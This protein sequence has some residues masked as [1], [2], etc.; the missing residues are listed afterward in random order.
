MMGGVKIVATAGAETARPDA[1]ARAIVGAVQTELLRRGR[2]V[3]YEY[4][5]HV[6]S[7][8]FA[9]EGNVLVFSADGEGDAALMRACTADIEAVMRE[10]YPFI[11]RF[12]VRV[13][14]K[15]EDPMD[16]KIKRAEQIFGSD[17]VT[18]K[19]GDDDNG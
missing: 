16:S 5:N 19:K 11:A 2:P 3:E 4:I 1:D 9:V 15:V 12:E 14:E 7:A 13:K 10:M 17:K 18:V 8:N 6:K